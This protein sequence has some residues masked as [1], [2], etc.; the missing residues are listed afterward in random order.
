MRRFKSV[1]FCFVTRFLSRRF[2]R[3]RP[4]PS[5]IHRVCRLD[6]FWE[7]VPPLDDSFSSTLTPPLALPTLSP[8]TPSPT[9]LSSSS[10]TCLADRFLYLVSCH[11]SSRRPQQQQMTPIQLQEGVLANVIDEVVDVEQSE[12]SNTSLSLTHSLILQR[13]TYIMIST[14]HL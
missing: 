2:V 11:S 12:S 6:F 13:T 1:G 9:H 10:T 8:V 4:S 14:K 5:V 3:L 7:F